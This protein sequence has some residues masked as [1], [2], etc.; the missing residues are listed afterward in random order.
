VVTIE[1]FRAGDLSSVT[2]YAGGWTSISRPAAFL[3]AYD[4]S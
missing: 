4:K 2:T 1:W 3:V